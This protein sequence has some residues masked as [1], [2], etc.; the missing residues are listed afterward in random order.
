MDEL[1]S[2]DVEG[3]IDSPKKAL[4]FFKDVCDKYLTI[5]DKRYIDVIFGTMMANRLDSDPVWLYVVGVPS[6]GKTI[7]VDPMDGHPTVYSL[8]RLGTKTLASGFVKPKGRPRKDGTVS[9]PVD[10]SLAPILDG[11]VLVIKD[12]TSMLGISKWDLHDVLGQLRDAFDGKLQMRFGTGEE[13]FYETKFGLIAATTN[14]KDNMIA[15]LSDLGERFLSYRLP[16]ISKSEESKR[17]LQAMKVE[18]TSEQK[19]ALRTAAHV[20]LDSVPVKGIVS[21]RVTKEQMLLIKQVS[22]FACKAR[23]YIKRC[24]YTNEPDV[25]QTEV[26]VRMAKQLCSLA[27]GIALI[28]GEKGVSKST[29]DLVRKTALD[30]VILKRLN[31]IRGFLLCSKNMDGIWGYVRAEDVA[32]FIGVGEAALKR[33]ID[34]LMMLD[35]L[36]REESMNEKNRPAFKYRIGDA[37]NVRKWMMIDP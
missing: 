11:K 10:P 3:E 22:M 19:D 8:S 16:D 1:D 32:D 9:K 4:A 36:E 20:L 17:A 35:L 23:T 30:S 15:E 34:D 6:S 26:C 21:P 33:Q 28:R 2:T 27:R 14:T 18:A 29:L 7:L 13:K 12:F 37:G 24:R 31:A 5:E 25:V